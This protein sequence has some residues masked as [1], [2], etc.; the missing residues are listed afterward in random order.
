MREDMCNR[1]NR[2]DEFNYG[3][4]SYTIEGVSKKRKIGKQVMK[5]QAKERENV[6]LSE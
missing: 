3:T 4:L 1:L 2:I 6:S 5:Y